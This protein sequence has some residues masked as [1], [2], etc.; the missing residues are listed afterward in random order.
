MDTTFPQD[1]VTTTEAMEV[2][3]N[4]SNPFSSPDYTNVAIVKTVV[5]SISVIASILVIMLIGFLKLWKFFSQRLILYLTITALLFSLS[6]IINTVDYHGAMSAF[7]TGFCS[8]SGF[9]T[10]VSGWMMLNCIT[11]ITVY[12]FL[13]AIFNINSESYEWAYLLWIFLV[14]FLFN[15]IPFIGNTYGKAGVWCWIEAYD[16]V[17]CEVR[18]LGRWLQFC[19]YYFPLYTLNAILLILYI[20]IGVN[21]CYK[22]RKSSDPNSK[23]VAKQTLREVA[24]LI[25]YPL[26]YFVLN[27]PLLINRIY[28]T[29]NPQEPS[30]VLW[31]LGGI[32]LPLL[33]ALTGI[34]F[35]F[36]TVVSKRHIWADFRARARG[37]SIKATEYPM[38]T[39]EVSDSMGAYLRYKP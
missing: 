25:A 3:L 4:C 35:T 32:A 30:L 5:A 18:L 9:M 34:V 10:Q 23:K 8:F 37:K 15:W 14:P 33:G 21:I 24:S 11:C 17:N 28:T 38:K 12:L 31:Y 29:A 2:N 22:R 26:I 19:L 36:A 7:L 20:I 27:I 16:L 6:N 13:R 1:N 39:D